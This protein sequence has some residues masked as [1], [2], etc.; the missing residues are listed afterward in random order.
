MARTKVSAKKVA[1]RKPKSKGKR[2]EQSLVRQGNRIP[3]LADQLVKEQMEG[4]LFLVFDKPEKVKY[5]VPGMGA[6]E[7]LRV[8]VRRSMDSPVIGYLPLQ[9]RMQPGWVQLCYE[10][11]YL[12]TLY[13]SCTTIQ[14]RFAR[15][16][17]T[18]HLQTSADRLLLKVMGNV[19][20]Q[21]RYYVHARGRI[22]E[23]IFRQAGQG[24]EDWDIPVFKEFLLKERFDAHWVPSEPY[25]NHE[26]QDPFSDEMKKHMSEF[27]IHINQYYC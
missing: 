27:S 10:I 24:G 26:G 17:K 12:K 14:S 25:L 1:G 7:R 8:P 11:A 9:Q 13:A 23:E 2:T 21:F 22:C 20:A 6:V 18:G 5:T 15:R 16:A 3:P 19:S 4:Y